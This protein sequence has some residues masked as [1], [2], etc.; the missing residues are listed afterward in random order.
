MNIDKIII[1]IFGPSTAG[2]STV[3]DLLRKEI[4]RLYVVDFDVVKHQLTNYHWQRDRAV[5]TDL[6]W[7]LLEQATSTGLAILG[8]LPPPQSID[9]NDKMKQIADAAGYTLL[10]VEITA[11]ES[12]LVARYK[13]RLQKLE[14]LGKVGHLKTLDEFVAILR[15][16]YVRPD[17]TLSFDSSALVPEEILGRLKQN[18][19][20]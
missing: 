8:L 6:S 3:S 5:M 17:G 16:G 10:S 1:N 9:D 7:R 19:I 4:D 11:P 12:V 13:E 2:K 15:K 20:K 18:L 14:E